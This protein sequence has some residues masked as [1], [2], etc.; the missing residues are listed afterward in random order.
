MTTQSPRHLLN[1]VIQKFKFEELESSV[2]LEFPEITWDQVRS[3]LIRNH[4]SFTTFNVLKIINHVIR[5][6]KLTEKDLKSRLSHLE[7]VEISRHS[8]RKMWHAYELKNRKN[9]FY[10]EYD[11]SEIE[12]SM[13]D[14]FNTLQMKMHIKSEVYNDVTYIVIRE[15]KSHRLSPICI[16]L[17]LEQD[18]FFCSNKSVTKEFLL[19]VVKSAGYSECKKILLSGKNISSLIKIHI[20]NKRNALDGNDMSV[21]EE[22]EE[23]PGVVSNMGIDFKQ[24]QNRREYL[25]KYLGSDEIIL[26]SLLVKNRN[27]PWAD[28]KI[29]AKLPD[30]KI[31]MQWEF[32]STNLKKFLSE[33]TDQRVL[34]TPLPDYAKHFLKSGRNE[35]TVQRDRYNDDL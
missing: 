13:F 14:Y 23:A 19:A 5:D 28:P 26:E 9:N 16:A 34:V 6:K 35:L 25:E 18:L 27:V 21:D 7:V 4:E 30:V 17:F 31:N 2:M 1:S 33:C 8:N 29:A 22:F 24:N 20:T 11:L 10:N 15:K 3:C 12:D 32:K